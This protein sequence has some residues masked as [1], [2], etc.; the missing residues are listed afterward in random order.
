MSVEIIHY[1]D[2]LCVWAFLGEARVEEIRAQ[3]GDEVEVEARFSSVFGDTASKIGRGWEAR[4]GYE[5]FAK[6]VQEAAARFGHVS[7]HS[8]LW[9]TTRPASSE[10]AHLFVKASQLVEARG[11]VAAG[12]SEGLASAL[13]RAFFCECRDIAH[14]DVQADVAGALDVPLSALETEIRSGTAYAA[15]A[16]DARGA[17]KSGVRGSPTL[18]LNE[19]RQQLYGNVGYRVIEANI[20]ELLREPNAGEVSWC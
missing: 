7:L 19:G 9:L 3:F 17:E 14:W 6:H 4:G 2:L 1:S 12:T 13:R 10:S 11:D 16:K 20:Q 8:D 18:V 15:L 5:G